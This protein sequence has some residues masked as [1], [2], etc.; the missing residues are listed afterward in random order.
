MNKRLIGVIV[1]LASIS[2]NGCEKKEP[3]ASTTVPAAQA[4]SKPTIG[5]SLLTLANPFFKVMGDSM[6]AEGTKRQY[7][8]S[9]T[10]AE[11]DQLNLELRRTLGITFVVVTHELPSIYTI[12]DRVVMLDARTKRIVATG[13]PA[14]LRDHA[15]DPWVQRFFRREVEPKRTGSAA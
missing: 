6:V 9:I 3:S 11:L 5:V 10:S 1:V 2:G 12:A 7:V 14:E 8:V 4:G 15:A 13:R